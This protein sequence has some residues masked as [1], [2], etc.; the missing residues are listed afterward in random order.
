[1]P[2]RSLP[3]SFS[4]AIG[5]LGFARRIRS[6]TPQNLDR[7][8]P[9]IGI[10]GFARRPSP[11]Q[12][13]GTL[14][15]VPRSGFW[16]LRDVHAT[17][18]TAENGWFQ[19]RDRDFGFCA[20]PTICQHKVRRRFQSRDRDFGFCASSSVKIQHFFHLFQSR[21][22]DFGFCA[23]LVICPGSPGQKKFQSRDRDFG[24]CALSRYFG[25][26]CGGPGVSVPRSGFWVLR[27]FGQERISRSCIS[28]SPA[29]G[30]LGFARTPKS[31]RRSP[32]RSFSPAIGILGFARLLWEGDGSFADKF[33]SRDRDFGFCASP[34]GLAPQ[35]SKGFSPA[36][37]ILG[38]A[39]SR[40]YRYQF[41]II[42]SF[43]PA[44][45]ILGFARL[46][47]G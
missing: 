31:G 42:E 43:S 32:K 27:G 26:G 7:F 4:P 8:S 47:P 38:F 18:F 29:I 13:K 3:G 33:Q 41:L 45:G 22:R 30:I 36:I 15:S 34:W 39:R 40:R 25:D 1:M 10:L 28:F 24:F 5:I 12:R 9:A 21:D 37:G 6:R 46:I 35:R 2:W 19:S 44:I 14:V 23:L 17:Y 16:V 20:K 11:L